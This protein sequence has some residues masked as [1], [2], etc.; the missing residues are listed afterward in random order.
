MGSRRE[1]SLVWAV[2]GNSKGQLGNGTTTQSSFLPCRVAFQLAPTQRIA[3][4]FCGYEHTFA[5]TSDGDVL[6]FGN[7]VK[8]QLGIGNTD[9]HSNPQRVHLLSGKGVVKMAAGL[10]HS[11]ALTES[12]DLYAFGDNLSGQLGLGHNF[13]AKEQTPQKV[14]PLGRAKITQLACGQDHTAVLTSSGELFMFGNNRDGALGLAGH[15]NEG[16]P[17]VASAPQLVTGLKGKHVVQ[18]G[19]GLQHTVALTAAGGVYCWGENGRGQLGTGDTQ[20]R[21]TPSLVCKPLSAFKCIHVA[22]G[23]QHTIA[24]TDSDDVYGFGSDRH[25]QLGLGRRGVIVP[26]PTRIVRLGGRRVKN[27]VGGAWHT[28]IGTVTGEQY[29]MGCILPSANSPPVAGG[30]AS[31]ATGATSSSD[32]FALSCGDFRRLLLPRGA[33]ACSKGHSLLYGQGLGPPPSA[34]REVSKSLG[35]LKCDFSRMLVRQ[36]PDVLFTPHAHHNSDSPH[37]HDSRIRSVGADS[38][39]SIGGAAVG[40]GEGEGNLSSGDHPVGGHLSVLKA[41][42]PPLYEHAASVVSRSQSRQATDADQPGERGTDSDGRMAAWRVCAP[43]GVPLDALQLVICYLYQDAGVFDKPKPETAETDRDYKYEDASYSGNTGDAAQSEPNRTRDRR[44]RLLSIRSK[45][46]VTDEDDEQLKHG[47]AEMSMN[48]WDEGDEGEHETAAGFGSFGGA[49]GGNG[50]YDGAGLDR[51]MRLMAAARTLKLT[52]LQGLC[53]KRAEAFIDCRT[54]HKVLRRAAEGGFPYLK[55]RCLEFCLVHLGEVC[56][57]PNSA[58]VVREL[59]SHPQVLADVLSLSAASEG[60]KHAAASEESFE[61]DGAIPC[62][63]ALRDEAACVVPA[64]DY[65]GDFLALFEEVA[66][67]SVAA[68]GGE[69]ISPPHPTQAGHAAKSRLDEKK[70][71]PT[72]GP[73]TSFAQ[74]NDKG[75]PPRISG[76][77]KRGGGVLVPGEKARAAGYKDVGERPAEAEG[78]FK[79]RAGEGMPAVTVHKSILA[80]RSGFF[81]AMLEGRMADAGQDELTLK[82]EPVVSVCALLEFIRFL[83][84]GRSGDDIEPL[85]A[86]EVLFLTKGDEG[87]DEGFF[88]VAGTDELRH[89]C[90]LRLFD[91]MDS[92]N[93]LSIL[94]RAKAFGDERV[95]EAAIDYI[96]GHFDSCMA[97]LKPPDGFRGEAEDGGGT[98][99]DSMTTLIPACLEDDESPAVD[100][101]LALAKRCTVQIKPGK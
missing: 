16:P 80:A 78:D 15:A 34:L 90:T 41:R 35:R 8:G 91:G 77:G 97:S 73:V 25:G 32:P 45:A 7:G 21:Y 27:C 18:I 3:E 54:V 47:T 12:G 44:D 40:E 39:P 62:I 37:D 53:E 72:P 71:Q 38:M 55:R 76:D 14:P 46:G 60:A 68:E 13:T 79:I 61:G 100:L 49:Y 58:E 24:V 83:Y 85:I 48:P 63:E 98:L 6:G 43:A 42:C 75:E 65:Q 5:L 95:L 92:D 11:L 50:K 101:L 10:E 74:G 70:R 23:G 19:C 33:E 22:C 51:L 69:E 30:G 99:E 93:A 26:V 17:I 86:L 89:F 67:E 9:S 64:E 2:G 28:I 94:V 88:Q 59:S 1:G 82:F 57:P 31:G 29:I 52:R 20:N 36:K 84:T 4:V 81:R 56:A 96:L 87:S 66:A